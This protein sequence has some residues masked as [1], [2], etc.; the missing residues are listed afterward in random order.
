M[1]RL[2]HRREGS[3]ALIGSF[4]YFICYSFLGFLLEVVFAKQSKAKKQDRKCRYFLP[5]CPVYGFGA[6]F[7]ISLPSPI[8]RHPLLLFC[9]GII[10]ASVTEF[11]IG[12]F[13]SQVLRTSFWD[14]TKMSHHFQGQI[15]LPFSIA[16]GLLSIPLI[17]GLHP[18]VSTLVARIPLALFLPAFYLFLADTAFTMCLL[19]H[20]QTAEVLRWYR[21][22]SRLM[23]RS[24]FYPSLPK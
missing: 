11:I 24:P 17:Y 16:W 4:W 20:F 22:K 5:I 6:L 9:L 18:L 21:A 14:Y 2:E 7:F 1:V 10:I 15:C 13:Y 23:M 3:L 12:V 19:R 8:Y